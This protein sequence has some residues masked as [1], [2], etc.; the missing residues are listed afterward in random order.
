MNVDAFG[1]DWRV[2][3]TDAAKM[4]S[5]PLPLQGNLDPQLMNGPWEAIELTALSILKEGESLPAH[6]FNLGHGVLPTVPVENVE[7]LIALVRTYKA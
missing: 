7:R 3:L 2:T 4:L 1:V 5:R 6:I